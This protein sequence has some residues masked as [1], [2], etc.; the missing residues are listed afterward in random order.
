M[1]ISKLLF[2]ISVILLAA[3]M[4]LGC[5]RSGKLDVA[6]VH[7]QVTIDG[8]P[9]KHGKIVFTPEQGREA[10][11]EIQA[12]GTFVLGTYGSSDGAIVGRHRVRIFAIEPIAAA[13]D[14]DD[15][16]FSFSY[17]IP[18]HYADPARSNLEFEVLPGDDNT[19]NI[20]LARP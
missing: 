20:K 11:G 9:L 4:A 6:P 13:A 17:S 16:D 10:Q 12:D 8:V 15:E 5:S 7:G 3:T 19:A 1:T 18:R 14:Y 2:C